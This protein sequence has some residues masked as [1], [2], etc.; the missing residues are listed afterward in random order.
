MHALAW[1]LNLLIFF[2]EYIYI[3][4]VNGME[5]SLCILLWDVGFFLFGEESKNI[6]IFIFFQNSILLC[7]QSTDWKC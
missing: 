5:G 1:G 4:C 3:V 6:V 2:G 7:L